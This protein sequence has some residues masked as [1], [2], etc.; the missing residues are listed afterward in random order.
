MNQKMF[1][2]LAIFYELNV[3]VRFNKDSNGIVGF[4][5]GRRVFQNEDLKFGE[6]EI[7]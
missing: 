2:E 5:S 1:N 6:I 7:R 4:Y 3:D